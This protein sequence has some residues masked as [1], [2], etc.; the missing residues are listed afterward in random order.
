MKPQKNLSILVR[1]WINNKTKPFLGKG[2]ILLL[3]NIRKH[4]SIRSA[5]KQMNMSYRKA[6]QM[7]EDMNNLSKTPL[8]TKRVGGKSGGGAILTKSGEN[9]IKVFYKIENHLQKTASQLL[10]KQII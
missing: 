6:W 3:E 9:T 7:I 1:L 10:K 8:V 5:A 2:R 4:G